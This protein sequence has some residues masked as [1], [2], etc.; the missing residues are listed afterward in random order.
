MTALSVCLLA[1][2]VTAPC[3]CCFAGVSSLIAVATARSGSP[4]PSDIKVVTS[5]NSFCLYL[6]APAPHLP[7]LTFCFIFCF[8]TPH[9]TLST[10]THMNTTDITDSHIYATL[11]FNLYSLLNKSVILGLGYNK[12][13]ARPAT[14]IYFLVNTQTSWLVL[15]TETWN[16][17]V[18]PHCRLLLFFWK[19]ISC[20]DGNAVCSSQTVAISLVAGSSLTR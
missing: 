9:T 18:S 6:P 8:T 4:G 20:W 10:H 7:C 3:C 13:G 15:K 14:D 5:S 2:S 11:L 12:M 19:K 17:V 16:T 1:V